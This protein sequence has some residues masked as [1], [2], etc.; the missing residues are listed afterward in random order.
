MI[1]VFASRVGI[2]LWIEIASSLFSSQET[3]ALG[4]T[5]KLV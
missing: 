2:F 1:E 4:G 3:N 5:A